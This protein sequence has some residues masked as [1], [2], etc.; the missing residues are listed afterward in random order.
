MITLVPA[1]GRDYKSTS[2]V[3]KALQSQID[4]RVQDIGSRWD[5]MVGNLRDIKNE[6]HS[7]VKVPYSKLQKATI[8]KMEDL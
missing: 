7:E 1:Y 2:A 4:F 8:L 3:K 5:G 6:G